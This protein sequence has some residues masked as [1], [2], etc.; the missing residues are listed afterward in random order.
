MKNSPS[1]P[2]GP[3][4]ERRRYDEPL[5][6]RSSQP[7]KPSGDDL[8]AAHRAKKA[9]ATAPGPTP[10]ELEKMSIVELRNLAHARYV[11]VSKC[12]ERRDMVRK[13]KEVIGSSQKATP[14]T[15]VKAE[16]QLFVYR[17]NRDGT[18]P[19]YLVPMVKDEDEDEGHEFFVEDLTTG[20]LRLQVPSS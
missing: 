12:L 3:A 16:E 19:G 17:P 1:E 9:A 5:P 2:H 20:E 10:E 4:C 14:M 6:S 13:L 7:S 8:K 15:A 11:D 18:V